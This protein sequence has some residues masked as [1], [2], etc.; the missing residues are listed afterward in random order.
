MW[1][2]WLNGTM[3]DVG[4]FIKDNYCSLYSYPTR[5]EAAKKVHYLN[6]GNV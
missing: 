6:G 4:Y 5:D 2:F 1:I 3:Y